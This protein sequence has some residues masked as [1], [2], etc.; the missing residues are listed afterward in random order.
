MRKVVLFL[1]ICVGIPFILL[2]CMGAA[3]AQS[4]ITV[5]D[6]FS[7]PTMGMMNMGVAFMEIKNN[8]ATDDAIIAAETP[9]A[10]RVELHNH[11][12]ENGIMKMRKMDTVELPA[13]QTTTLKPGGLHI[14]LFNLKQEL[15]AGDSFPLILKLKSG[16]TVETTVKVEDRE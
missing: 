16:E 8:G 15:K 14:M 13:N 3:S 2:K 11:I 4:P 5:S 1:A 10:A 6:A 9:I 7:Y 12:H